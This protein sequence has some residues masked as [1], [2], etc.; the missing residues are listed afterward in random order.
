[1]TTGAELPS[2]TFC[3]LPWIHLATTVDGVWGRCCFDATN[4]YDRYYR[5]SEAPDFQL[6]EDA[7]GC[8]RNSRYAAANPDRVMGL[9]E[10]FNSPALRRTRLQML[11]GDAP[12]ACHSCFDQEAL[13]VESHRSHV[14]R[15]FRASTDFAA[16]AERIAP[17]GT[18]P[19]FPFYLDLR[20]GNTCNLS[21]IM[22]SFPISSR[23]GAG[24]VP[25]WSPAVINPYRDD[26]ELWTELRERCHNVRYIYVA[27]G[28]PFLQADHFRVLRLLVEE[29]AAQHIS[30]QYNTNLTV[31]PDEALTLLHHFGE[32]VL[33]ASCDGT[34]ELFEAIRV[35]ARWPQFVANLRKVKQHFPVSLDVTVQRDNV[36]ALR[37]LIAFADGEGVAIRF[38]N[39]L[40][41]PPELSV[42]ALSA[43][44]KDLQHGGLLRL[45]AECERARRDFLADQIKR[46]DEYMTSQG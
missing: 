22:C 6:D 39:I 7:I 17:D 29:D 23:L 1:V 42:R 4:D 41:S 15:R 27:G 3:V 20:F 35:G 36:H 25:S 16:L 26:A 46:I 34:G 31:V 33:G 5:E 40:Q 9:A 28:E 24:R 30:L 45:A 44:S 12:R 37:E 18:S 14:N 8:L 11:N 21:C 19:E 2:A 43:T 32:V 38:E 13:G 10:A